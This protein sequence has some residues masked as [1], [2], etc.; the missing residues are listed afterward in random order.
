MERSIEG[1]RVLAAI[2]SG[3]QARDAIAAHLR[4]PGSEVDAHLATLLEGDFVR[5]DAGRLLLT[6]RVTRLLD[7][8][9]GRLDL[10]A[11]AAPIVLDAER[12]LEGRIDVEIPSA[13]DAAAV[14]DRGPFALVT[15]DHG[16]RALL[17]SVLDATGETA[18]ILRMR[19]EGA[20]PEAIEVLGSEL[21]AVA[22]TIS[23]QLPRRK[24]RGFEPLADR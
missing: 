24:D 8:L 16:H 18:C 11:I 10:L 13:S 19:V 21:A 23:G 2:A 22:S 4:L 14:P 3:A 1:F 6:D 15:D 7:G 12:R 17:A 9:V 5:L 20:A